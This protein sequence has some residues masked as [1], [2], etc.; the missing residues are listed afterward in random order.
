MSDEDALTTSAVTDRVDTSRQGT[1]L[2]LGGAVQR[3][4]RSPHRRRVATQNGEA[5]AMFGVELMWCGGW[6]LQ[7][8]GGPLRAS[9]P[10]GV[11][12]ALTRGSRRR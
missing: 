10:R 11:A 4:S 6:A 3:A 1:A 5:S 12:A 7:E 9:G 2:A 8:Q